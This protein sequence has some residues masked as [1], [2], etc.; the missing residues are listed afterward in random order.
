MELLDVTIC[1]IVQS[2]PS[3]SLWASGVYASH[4]AFLFHS[5][6]ARNNLNSIKKQG[7]ETTHDDSYFRPI[8]LAHSWLFIKG[9]LSYGIPR[10]GVQ[11]IA[12]FL[13][14]RWLSNFW[15]WLSLIRGTACR[16]NW[17]YQ[18]IA[19]NEAFPFGVDG[20]FIG[21]IRANFMCF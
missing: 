11:N 1:V 4:C 6:V 10:L 20:P 7:C 3:Q 18:A 5:K 8:Y 17:K 9:L 12:T 15:V 16:V 14:L 21:S 19:L 13:Y 2:L